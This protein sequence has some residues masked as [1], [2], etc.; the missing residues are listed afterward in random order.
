[1]SAAGRAAHGR[2]KARHAQREFGHTKPKLQPVGSDTAWLS[3]WLE[4]L[5]L[6]DVFNVNSPVV[7]GLHE[8][9]AELEL[10]LRKASQLG[11]LSMTAHRENGVF[12]EFRWRVL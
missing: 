7:L 9:S 4:G 6:G 3:A 2:N 10:M 8:D 12:V 5:S 1:M 11:V